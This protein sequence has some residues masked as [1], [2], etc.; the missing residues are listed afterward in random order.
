MFLPLMS[1]TGKSSSSSGQPVPWRRRF[2]Q[3]FKPIVVKQA[4]HY[5]L[6]P[7]F[8]WALMTVESSYNPWAISR[9]GAR[10]LMQVMPQTDGLVAD[11]MTWRN[12]GPALLLEPEVAIEM[13]GWYFHQLLEKFNGQLPLAIA[14][15]NAGPHRVALWLR[16]KGQ[17][18][19]DEFIEEIP[20]TEARRYTKRVLSY[21]ALYRRIYSGTPGVWV[22]QTIDVNYQDNINF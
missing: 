6:D 10:G 22:G 20:Y 1:R 9:A 16:R 17:L 15:Y 11:R 18:S 13:S 12:F 4:A 7:S 5:G 21:L 14:G 19:M 2:P 3:A 8:I